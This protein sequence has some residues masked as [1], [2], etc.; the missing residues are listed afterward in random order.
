[1]PLSFTIVLKRKTEKLYVTLDFENGLAIDALLF[2]GAYVSAIAETELDKIK[3]RARAKTSKKNDPPNFP[4]EV[5][6]GQLEKALATA[7]LNF[8]LG[9]PNFAEYFAVM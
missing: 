9:D 1:M 6:N 3:Q 5:A 8:D 4:I 7:T 2:S